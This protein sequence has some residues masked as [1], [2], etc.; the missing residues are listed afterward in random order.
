MTKAEKRTRKRENQAK[1]RAA[2]V[3]AA[4]RRNRIDLVKRGSIIIVLV[5]IVGGGIAY[6]LNK[7]DSKKVETTDQSSPDPTLAPE[8]CD[9]APATTSTDVASTETTLYSEERLSTQCQ[10][11]ATIT[12]NKGVIELELDTVSA[13][14]AASHFAAL[15]RE[16]FYDGR[17]FH[18]VVD[19]FMIQGG[20]ADGVSG[21]EVDGE[22]PTDNY[23]IGSLAAAKTGADPAGTFDAQ[24]FI[25]TGEQ[26][27]TLPN[28]YARFGRVIEG[29]EVAQAIA[30]LQDAPKDTPTE[31]ITIESITITEAPLGSATTAA[32]AAP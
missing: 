16:G 2:A 25:V 15:A 17:T 23:P 8:Q 10:Y 6:L 4:R 19:G 7:D 22:V 29:L 9:N 32:T 11:I 18:R 13:Q 26:G 1:A 30:K 28:D 5:L 24:F 14:V 3:V 12:T 27:Q 20:D 21:R 31:T